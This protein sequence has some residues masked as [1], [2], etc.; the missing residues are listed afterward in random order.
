MTSE[1]HKA[2]AKRL[3]DGGFQGKDR[4]DQKHEVK[5]MQIELKEKLRDAEV[6]LQ[7]HL[8]GAMARKKKALE[9]VDAMD[10]MIAAY[11]PGFRDYL[12]TSAQEETD[13]SNAA[14]MD[15]DGKR[16][17][18]PK[19]M[20]QTL[21]LRAEILEIFGS[22]IEKREKILAMTA[23]MPESITINLNLNTPEGEQPSVVEAETYDVGEDFKDLT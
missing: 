9:H 3:A 13:L 4:M 20:G 19:T 17:Y 14:I 2:A 15:S 6:A 16:T 8:L 11:C 1:S 10:E 22:V 7:N 5:W 23:E 21:K 18:P 12:A